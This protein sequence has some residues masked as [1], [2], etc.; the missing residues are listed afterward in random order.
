MN[1]INCSQLNIADY[2]ST[3]VGNFPIMN[4]SNLIFSRDNF[5]L[6]S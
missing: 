1:N 6:K 2:K 3:T 4:I 5:K